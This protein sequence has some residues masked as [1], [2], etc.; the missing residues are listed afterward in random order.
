MKRAVTTLPLHYG[1]APRWLFDK[2]K[3]LSAAVVSMILLEFGPREVL[4]RLSDPLWFQAFGCVVGFDWH[5]SGLTTTLCG[6][7]KEGIASATSDFPL[8]ICGGKAA[9]SRRTPQELIDCGNAW[10]MDVTTFIALSRLCAKIDNSLI[11]DGYNIYHHT[12]ILSKEGDWAII[13]Q[14]M[15]E[16]TRTARRYQWFSRENL[17]LFCE[18]HTG[19]TC[20]RQRDTLNLVARESAPVH[21]AAVDFTKQDPDWMSKTW[22]E[23]A[24]AMPERH[25]I[26]AKDVDAGRLGRMFRTLHEVRPDTF[27]DLVQIQGVGPR[28]IAALSLVSELVYNAPPSFKDPA[29]FSFAHG[30]KD[31]HPFPV[32]RKTYEESIAFLQSCLDKARINDRDKIEAF[33]RLNR[34][35]NTSSSV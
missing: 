12:F 35:Y 5:S 34:Y 27:K 26:A 20:D 22:G 23:I 31:G 9:T 24:L 14:G 6:A 17:D 21:A 10:D 30:G 32:Q 11:Q 28:T 8:A 19:V 15:S 4:R 13:Q 1:K 16:E 33:K 25:Y 2:M 7:L 3:R 18:P 29:R